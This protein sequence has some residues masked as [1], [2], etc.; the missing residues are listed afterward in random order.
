M[1]LVGGAEIQESVG[2]P[3]PPHPPAM[4]V[5]LRPDTVAES[6]N[7]KSARVTL[8]DGDLSAMADVEVGDEKRTVSA[9]A[10][11]LIS[12]G[13]GSDLLDVYRGSITEAE[14]DPSEPERVN[15][16]CHDYFKDLFDR[17]VTTPKYDSNYRGW[18]GLHSG[19]WTV[20][21]VVVDLARTFNVPLGTVDPT[22]DV[23]EVPAFVQ[24]RLGDVFQR[25]LQVEF[26]KARIGADGLLRVR[27]IRL[28]G[29]PDHVA[30]EGVNLAEF[31]P[32]R[33]R[34]TA[35]VNK[36]LVVGSTLEG[37]QLAHPP[38]DLAVETFTV[39][40]QSTIVRTI[41][42]PDSVNDA[43]LIH[44]ARLTEEVSYD[45]ITVDV[46]QTDE[47]EAA[48]AFEFVGGAGQ[49]LIAVKDVTVTN[50]SGGGETPDVDLYV[51]YADGTCQ[52]LAQGLQQNASFSGTLSKPVHAFMARVSSWHRNQKAGDE[53][54]TAKASLQ[55]TVTPM[56]F[57]EMI[58]DGNVHRLSVF[59]FSNV[60]TVIPQ[61]PPNPCDRTFTGPHGLKSGWT[62]TDAGVLD[63]DDLGQIFTT[64][65]SSTPTSYEV[66]IQSTWTQDPVQVEITVRGRRWSETRP[67]VLFFSETDNFS[68]SVYGE[69]TMIVENQ[70]ISNEFQASAIARSILAGAS[71]FLDEYEIVV[72]GN[73]QIEPADLIEIRLHREDLV[74]RFGSTMTI[75]ALEV[76]HEFAKTDSAGRIF[77]TR[78]N[79]IKASQAALSVFRNFGTTTIKERADAAVDY[80]RAFKLARIIQI[81]RPNSS[82]APTPSSSGPDRNVYDVKL[83]TE[84]NAVIREV[85]NA[86]TEPLA[87][88]DTVF[89]EFEDG[90]R[91]RPWI[92]GRADRLLTVDDDL[93]REPPEIPPEQIARFQI[94]T[95]SP[96]PTAVVGIFYSV[97]IEVVG[98]TGTTFTWDIPYGTLPPGLALIQ[99]GSRIA[100]IEGVAFS[101]IDAFFAL[102]V[103][104]DR[105][106]IDVEDYRLAV[107][108]SSG[109]IPDQFPPQVKIVDP[110]D[111]QTLAGTYVVKVDASDDAGPPRVEL[112]VGAFL[113]GILNTPAYDFPIRTNAFDDGD[114]SI[115]AAAIDSTGKTA[116]DSIDISFSNGSGAGKGTSGGN[117]VIVTAGLPQATINQGYQGYVFAKG[118]TSTYQWSIVSGS[119]PPGL[120]IESGTPS[121]TISG[122][123]TQT[124]L[125]QFTVRVSD[126]VNFDE[127]PLSILVDSFAISFAGWVENAPYNVSGTNDPADWTSVLS[128]SGGTGPF[129]WNWTLRQVSV[130]SS[131]ISVS[132]SEDVPGSK[133]TT[134]ATR[135]GDGSKIWEFVAT[136]SPS[137]RDLNFTRTFVDATAP[138]EVIVDFDVFVTDQSN[139]KSTVPVI[140]RHHTGPDSIFGGSG[141]GGGGSVPL[142][143][144][145]DSNLGTVDQGIF[146]SIPIQANGGT[147]NYSWELTSGSLP[148]GMALSPIG[149]PNT[150]I[151]GTPT[152]AGTF[153]FTIRV[154]DQVFDSDSKA[155][156][157]NVRGLT[158]QGPNRILALWNRSFPSRN[159]R[160]DGGVPSYDW[161]IESAVINSGAGWTVEIQNGGTRLIYKKNGQTKSIFDFIDQPGNDP[162]FTVTRTFVDPNVQDDVSSSIR[163]RVRDGNGS[164]AR[165]TFLL[166]Q[167]RATFSGT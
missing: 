46:S 119:L 17:I 89:V 145:T 95:T 62:V 13:Y 91:S 128:V 167:G 30:E 63:Q 42:I 149:T 136:A 86:G 72:G 3:D 74:A 163:I 53:P 44:E 99:D 161:I 103:R 57:P 76:S 104:D 110:T 29:D 64:K 165:K 10:D 65:K 156:V 157:L 144:A 109:G 140:A 50:F 134:T 16:S 162:N 121:A 25:I 155:F 9:D 4:N 75:Y 139:G 127:L 66:E 32:R 105:E 126:G 135:D 69:K 34:R 154:V 112:R 83:L 56:S 61:V 98:G 21:D 38:A 2:R 158:I 113:V 138:E 159:F 67:R 1:A 33:G 37:I 85:P 52:L 43:T 153:N 68:V 166:D 114:Y 116:G 130:P 117:L 60:T 107:V 79:G 100:R 19:D 51:L 27:K 148:D 132:V 151:S 5:V 6:L 102:R 92:I 131:G 12:M 115:T 123:P 8:T 22:T 39:E 133:W 106:N 59:P 96:L 111:Q 164:E 88:A 90:D 122:I 55:A 77:L 28:A 47:G 142:T 124:G 73:P 81:R 87:E 141:G 58:D 94:V 41:V 26:M 48:F 150:T 137:S 11:V 108:G 31:A 147:G 36:V 70:A 45:P 14:K 80:A 23:V 152:V 7:W 143:I 18:D 78:V 20:S 125:F 146:S 120:S 49:K 24:D 82:S 71:S 35:V 15:C 118:G 129:L 93:I 84:E 97:E 54:R 160:A 101:T 40:P